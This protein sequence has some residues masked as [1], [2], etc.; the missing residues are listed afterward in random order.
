MKNE[1][2]DLGIPGLDKLLKGGIPR[3]NTILVTGAPGTGKS[4][5][6]LQFLVDGANKKEAGVYVTSEESLESINQNAESL[7]INLEELEKKNLISIIP[8][9][10]TGKILSLEEPLKQIRKNKAKRIV[11]DSLTMFEFIYDKDYRRGLISFLTETKELGVTLL[12]ISENFSSNISDMVF[13]EED[14]L[15]DGLILLFKIRKGASFERCIHIAKMRG[16]NY[17][18]N[19]YPL[20]I[21]KGG[22]K[23]LTDQIPFS[24]SEKEF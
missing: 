11:I 18:I 13:K 12:A 19:I 6:G 5:F 21:T 14:F 24:L 4:I 10:V 3:V 22:M 20:T 17:P 9:S 16:E 8:Q 2:I 15:F 1:R 7:G 23:I